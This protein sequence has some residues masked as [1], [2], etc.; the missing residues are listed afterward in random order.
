MKLPTVHSQTHTIELRSWLVASILVP[1]LGAPSTTFAI[2]AKKSSADPTL[3]IVIALDMATSLATDSVK[4]N[5]L[6]DLI[7]ECQS[8]SGNLCGF[9]TEGNFSRRR[10]KG[11]RT[12]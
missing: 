7:H 6:C 3:A 11:H 2:G 10:R 1:D 4:S 12:N 8:I 9:V 5:S